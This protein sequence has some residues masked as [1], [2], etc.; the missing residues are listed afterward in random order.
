MIDYVYIIIDS[1]E[2]LAHQP[3]LW[4]HFKMVCHKGTYVRSLVRDM[5]QSLGCYGYA[6]DIFRENVGQFDANHSFVFEKLAL[7]CSTRQAC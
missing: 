6:D 7:E 2:I 4:T 1:I 5:G 3:G